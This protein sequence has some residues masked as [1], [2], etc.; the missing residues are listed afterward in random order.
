MSKER[1]R[2]QPYDYKPRIVARGGKFRIE[3]RGAITREECLRVRYTFEQ[4]IT[5][6]HQIASYQARQ[7]RLAPKAA[8]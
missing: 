8:V 7:L 1:L 5:E 6:A 3:Y 2:D 4:A